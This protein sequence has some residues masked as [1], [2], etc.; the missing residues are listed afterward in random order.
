MK[1]LPV[2]SFPKFYT[3]L[4]KPLRF[5]FQQELER[6]RTAL[7]LRQS[8]VAWEHLERAHIIGQRYPGAHSYVHFKML[9]FG[10]RTKNT[11]EIVGQL[12]RLMF[13]G[14]KSFVGMVPEGNPGGAHVPALQAFPIPEDLQ[15]IFVKAGL[16]RNGARP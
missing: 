8:K 1:S 9:V 2:F 15:E 16:S 11:K 4:P 12:P 10:F 6:Y 3:T 13:G 5:H 14:V 7:V